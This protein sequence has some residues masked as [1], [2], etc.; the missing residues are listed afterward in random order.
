[1]AIKRR[2]ATVPLLRGSVGRV[3]LTAPI[4]VARI[5][6]RVSD[7]HTHQTLLAIQF[8]LR[9]TN[10]FASFNRDTTK[11]FVHRVEKRT[12]QA[13]TLLRVLDRQRSL[14]TR[15]IEYRAAP[16]QA[17]LMPQPVTPERV[18]RHGLFP[19]TPMMFVKP[20]AA[21]S[22]TKSPA[23]QRELQTE[24]TKRAS[25]EVESAHN[26]AQTPLTLPSQEL[27]RVTDHVIKQLD[28]R[29]LSY[30]ERTGRM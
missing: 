9:L 22:A 27:S 28:R 23:S 13:E 18:K 19:R 26:A 4:P 1:M 8:A 15:V 20:H 11:T 14:E 21:V 5:L 7:A 24:I 16:P 2:R 29:V 30:R 12:H 6:R 10:R 17:E 3:E 25:H